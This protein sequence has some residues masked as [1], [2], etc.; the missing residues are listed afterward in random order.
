VQ[1]LNAHEHLIEQAGG[2]QKRSTGFHGKFI[3]V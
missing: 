3:P 2:L 1:V